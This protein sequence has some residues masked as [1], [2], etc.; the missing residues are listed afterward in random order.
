MPRAPSDILVK[1]I[2]DLIDQPTKKHDH[3]AQ[4]DADNSQPNVGVERRHHA[5]PQRLTMCVKD[6]NIRQ[7]DMR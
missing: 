1:R 3:K 2:I 6:R 7:S 4:D 5:L